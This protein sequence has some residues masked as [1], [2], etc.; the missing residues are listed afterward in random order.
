LIYAI[1]LNAVAEGSVVRRTGY[2]VGVPA[3]SYGGFKHRA[4][5]PVLAYRSL[6]SPL[7][8]RMWKL[9]IS[10]ALSLVNNNNRILSSV[11]RLTFGN[12]GGRLGEC[13]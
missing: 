1:G 2:N 11:S 5:K 10:G 7:Y 12:S 9:R 6:P 8:L 3:L 13:C 4:I